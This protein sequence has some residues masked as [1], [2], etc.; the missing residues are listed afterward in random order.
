ML[1]PLGAS[2]RARGDPLS[3]GAIA[4][5]FAYLAATG[6]DLELALVER[7]SGREEEALR[8]EPVMPELDDLVRPDVRPQGADEP[9][10]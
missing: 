4:I 6:E 2:D 7:P 8:A 10:C 3:K 9:P 5:R 1:G